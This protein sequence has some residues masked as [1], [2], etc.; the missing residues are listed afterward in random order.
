ME[1]KGRRIFD[2]IGFDASKESKPKLTPAKLLSKYNEWEYNVESADWINTMT[3]EVLKDYKMP[4]H[5]QAILTH[6]IDVTN[7]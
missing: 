1:M 4:S 2:R 3:G 5:L 6:N 7:T